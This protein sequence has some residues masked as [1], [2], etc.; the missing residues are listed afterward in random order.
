MLRQYLRDRRRQ[1]G[2]AMVNVTNRPDVA[3]RLIPIKFLFRHKIA[4]PRL[5]VIQ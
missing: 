3:V 2:L 5:S 4:V 1:R